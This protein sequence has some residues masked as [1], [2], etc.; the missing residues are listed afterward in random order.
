MASRSWLPVLQIV[1]ER[2]ARQLIVQQGR[3]CMYVYMSVTLRNVINVNVRRARCRD[4][5]H[6]AS[7]TQHPAHARTYTYMASTT[8]AHASY[9]W[10][11]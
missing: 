9:W 10:R 8:H 7:A 6:M 2:E 1:A 4:M 3:R 11:L 5:Y